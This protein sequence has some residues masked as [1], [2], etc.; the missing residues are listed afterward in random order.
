VHKNGKAVDP[1]KAELPRPSKLEGTELAEFKLSQVRMFL[2]V[3]K[4]RLMKSALASLKPEAIA[5][6]AL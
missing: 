3:A 5:K 2:Q 4:Q 6:A 1:L